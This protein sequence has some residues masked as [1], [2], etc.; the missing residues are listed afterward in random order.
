[1]VYADPNLIGYLPFC[2]LS[3]KNFISIIVICQKDYFERK[4]NNL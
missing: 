2:K 3:L 4:L 1:M